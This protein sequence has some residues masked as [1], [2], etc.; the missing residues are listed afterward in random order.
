M[1]AEFAAQTD[2]GLK[3]KYNEDSFLVDELTR[4]FVVADGMGGH[5]AGDVASKVA[6]E[7]VWDFCRQIP[8]ESMADEMP[9]GQD[10]NLSFNANRLINAI[11]KANSRIRDIS[12]SSDEMAGM[13]TTVTAVAMNG[14]CVTI[15]NVGDSRCYL[16]AQTGAKLLTEDHSWVNEQLKKNLITEEDAKNHPW[17][18]VITR[19]LGSRDVVD[20]DTFEHELSDGDVLCLCTDGLSGMVDD[21]T[22][23]ELLTQQE[24]SLPERCGAI[25]DLAKQNGGVDNI[26]VI[27]LE[28]RSD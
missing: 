1:K 25:V 13:G 20:V 16:F 12:T 9:Y 5:A 28:F 15:A 21:V 18:N 14:G 6:V 7:A 26:T 10:G 22:L 4:V 8:D 19:A 27:L 24:T 3:R 23:F 11:K 2:V 17:R